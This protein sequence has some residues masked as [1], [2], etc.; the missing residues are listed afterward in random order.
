MKRLKHALALVLC[1]CSVTLYAAE[2]PVSPNASPE[3]Q[4]LLTYLYDISG[5]KLLSGQ[6]N[7]PLN[8][9][10]RLAGMRCCPFTMN[11]KRLAIRFREN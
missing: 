2:K 4:A 10:N 3:A 5:K 9:S 11:R 1:A 6:H 7:A 8:G